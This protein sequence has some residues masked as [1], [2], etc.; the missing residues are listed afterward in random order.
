MDNNHQNDKRREHRAPLEIITLPFLATRDEDQQPFEYL[1]L[2]VSPGGARFALPKWVSSRERLE[3]GTVINLHL[4]LLSEG[5]SCAKGKVVRAWYDETIYSNL[6]AVSLFQRGPTSSPFAIS[7]ENS[8]IVVDMENIESLPTHLARTV[9]DCFLLKKGVTV[10][11]KHLIPYFSR[12]GG[13]SESDYP[14]LKDTV[15]TEIR[16][17]VLASQDSLSTLYQQL[18]TDCLKN[19]DI[20]KYLNLE[21]LRGLIESEISS[22]I[23]AATFESEKIAPYISAIKELEKKLY[24]NY[25]IAVLIYLLSL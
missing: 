9:K 5:T 12:I 2:D 24:D 19:D 21:E 22:D 25:N 7:A 16:D 15:L 17:R 13:Y 14:L 8:D 3:T 10:Y 11:L 20:P 4:T 6:C 23:F 1:L 18:A